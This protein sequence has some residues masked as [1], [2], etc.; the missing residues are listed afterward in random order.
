MAIPEEPETYSVPR[1]A[2]MIVSA[3]KAFEGNLLN[4]LLER[5]YGHGTPGHYNK[6]VTLY[7]LL[8]L[9]MAPP[10]VL[11]FEPAAY[12]GSSMLV[13]RDLPDIGT[14]TSGRSQTVVV[15]RVIAAPTITPGL[16]E[17]GTSVM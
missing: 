10:S 2:S 3:L 11:L 9:S 12:N 15:T 14:E 8:N 6:H 1:E 16:A 7:H 4:V 5:K 13:A 17:L